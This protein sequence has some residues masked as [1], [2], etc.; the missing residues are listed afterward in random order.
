MRCSLKADAGASAPLGGGHGTLVVAGLSA[1]W[2][3][4]DAVRAGWRVVALDL[5]GDADTRRLAA[6]WAPIG[7][8]ERL[9][10]DGA[11]LRHELARAA[12]LDG[13]LAWV[14]GGGTEA[15]LS[16]LDAGGGALPRWGMARETIAALR[17]PSCFFGLLDRLGLPH[18]PWRRTAPDA[19]QGWVVKHPGGSGGWHIRDASAINPSP[20]DPRQ[21]FQRQVPGRSM[22]ALCLADGARGRVMGLSAQRALPWPPPP[23][24]PRHPWVWQGVVGPVH[25]PA[26]QARVAQALA[27]L[28]PALGLSGLFSLDFMADGDE[29]CFLELN[30]RPSA[31]LQV[32]PPP[33]PHGWL[34]AHR[35]AL[36]GRLPAPSGLLPTACCGVATLWAPCDLRLS[37]GIA[38]A[39]AAD[40]AVCDLPHAGSAFNAGEPVCSLR[41]T[42]STD[43]H[44]SAD[45]PAQVETRLQQLLS[46][47][48]RRLM[49]DAVVAARAPTLL[50]R[51]TEPTVPRH[52][53]AAP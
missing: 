35:E 48:R 20:A 32:H 26:L 25:Q 52:E 23:A 41:S 18:P 17:D 34:G 38:A 44:G 22:S 31:S 16:L 6:R 30:P 4:E 36:A 14:A 19:M 2:L 7:T 1:R 11:Q 8:P 12:A 28:V 9:S 37:T 53:E 40:P 42:L 27:A 15:D 24:A 49:N 50:S 21:Y 46:P 5:F 10:I 43:D 39:L 51:S 33:G 45:A 3:V 29:A 13:A 47:W